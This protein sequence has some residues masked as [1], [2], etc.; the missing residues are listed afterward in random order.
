MISFF[1]L[2][3]SKRT[4]I[5]N[6]ELITFLMG[7]VEVIATHISREC[8]QCSARGFVCEMCENAK[9]IYAFD[10]LNVASCRGCNTF[11][12]RRCTVENKSCRR[13]QRLRVRKAQEAA[14]SS[15]NGRSAISTLAIGL[16][17]DRESFVAQQ[18]KRM[19]AQEERRRR[20]SS[21]EG[22]N[23]FLTMPINYMPT[24]AT[25]RGGGGADGRNGTGRGGGGD[26]GGGGGGHQDQVP[27]D[28]GVSAGGPDEAP[29]LD[30]E[31]SKASKKNWHWRRG[32]YMDENK[33][34]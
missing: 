32:S 9:P 2:F 27:R 34:L 31:P 33:V 11:V 16:M 24:A 21:T 1:F 13:C 17:D 12:H 18:T 25:S 5:N 20:R 29:M 23:S 22:S 14:S 10:I 28:R 8:A 19:A 7:V 3:P 15:S 26:G 30:V 4:Q 6:K